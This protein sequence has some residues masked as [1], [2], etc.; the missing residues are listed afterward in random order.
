MEANHLCSVMRG[1]EQPNS[2][3]RTQALRGVFRRDRQLLEHIMR[4]N[5]E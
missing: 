2:M 5:A 3:M 4:R 1:V